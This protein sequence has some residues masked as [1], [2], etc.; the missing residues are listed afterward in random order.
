MI[1]A[2]IIILVLGWIIFEQFIAKKNQKEH[3]EKFKDIELKRNKMFRENPDFLKNVIKINAISDILVS[4]KIEKLEICHTSEEDYQVDQIIKDIFVIYDE[5]PF[6]LRLLASRIQSICYITTT[7]DNEI[8]IKIE[9]STEENNDKTVDKI[10]TVMK[11]VA[12]SFKT[13]NE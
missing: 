7:L 5:T 4:S 2:L 12:E 9:C 11:R 3:Q 10:L 13:K 6:S 8:F 1:L